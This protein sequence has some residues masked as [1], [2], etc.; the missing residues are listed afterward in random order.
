MRLQNPFAALSPTG[1]DSQVLVVLARTEQYLTIMQIHRLLPEGGSLG[2]V[3][4]S[5]VRLAE[6]DT[7]LERVTGR[8]YAYALNRDHLLAESIIR[9]ST[10]K[11]ELVRRLAEGIA[12]WNV[13]PLTAKLFGSAVRDEMTEGSDI[14]LFIVMPE[15]LDRDEATELVEDLAWHA[16]QWTGNEVR[17]LMYFSGEVQP[18]S[19]FDSILTEGIDIAG[20]PSWLRRHLRHSESL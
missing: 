18:A 8:S 1:I 17:P 12:E 13:Q 6:Q 4:N 10:A 7:V 15:E 14:D 9:I 2:G 16:Q 11:Q 20:D 3:R 19:I 5:V